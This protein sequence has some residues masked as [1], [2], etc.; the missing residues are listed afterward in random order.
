MRMKLLRFLTRSAGD[1]PFAVFF[2]AALLLLPIAVVVAS[3]F[4]PAG[5][6]WQ[7]LW[8]STLPTYLRNTLA[9]AVGV[10]LVA[11]LVGTLSAWLTSRYEF[12]GRRIAEF[13]L[14]LPLA[15]PTYIAAYTYTGFV[16]YAGPL[17]SL[18]EVLG[19][20]VTG[21]LH[22]LPIA[23]RAGLVFTMAMVLYPYVYLTARAAFAGRSA[24][25]LEAAR[26]LG[27]G[28]GLFT[29]VA[30]P[31]A[32]PA[33]AAG[34]LLVLMESLA[35]YGAPFYLGVDTL[36]T[37]I[38]RSWFAAGNV[39]VALKLSS[40]LLLLLV[41]ATAV[42]RLGR[43]RARYAEGASVA[44]TGGN[45]IRLAGTRGVAAALLCALPVA[46]GF[47]VPVGML[48]YW[49]SL[50]GVV[51]ASSFAALPG[52]ALGTLS[53]SGTAAA[54]ALVVAFGFS[55]V[56][57]PGSTAGG[58]TRGLI[59]VAVSGYAVPGAVIAVGVLVVT[60]FS[61]RLLEPIV[62]AVSGTD[63]RGILTGSFAALLYAYLVRY[64]AV[65][66]RPLVAGFAGIGVGMEHASRA[67]G[68]AKLS[69][70][71]RV[72]LPLARSSMAAAF[73]LVFIDVSKEL[74]L[75]L[76][77]RP[78]NFETLAVRAFNLASEERLLQAALPSLL[79]IFVGVGGMLGA[80]SLLGYLQRNR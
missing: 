61:D 41:V 14:V 1:R 78:F 7:Q 71:L 68:R 59:S 79:L 33:I 38:F 36:T 69:T 47:G 29:R 57:R 35:A 80:G 46:V 66:Y 76:V 43:R 11:G 70:L 67:L 8:R 27:V 3:V 44:R 17:S 64:L 13:A 16:G 73:M 34:M 26:S 30:L 20:S 10:P 77:L 31:L 23:S 2:G 53:A 22:I 75:T 24:R 40:L 58:A 32:R 52:P 65:A 4:I 15:V 54:L 28:R 9:V 39:I 74:P 56:T 37:G 50:T 51:D 45:R 12:P 49:W 25:L 48:L 72:Q 19:I 42:E 62:T 6:V 21:R 55:W 60:S 18:L 5:G 63:P